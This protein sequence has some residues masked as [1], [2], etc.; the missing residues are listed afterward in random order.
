MILQNDQ[1]VHVVIGW[2]GLALSLS[3]VPVN[4]KECEWRAILKLRFKIY[5]SPELGA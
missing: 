2:L 1:G 4:W 5:L 3:S